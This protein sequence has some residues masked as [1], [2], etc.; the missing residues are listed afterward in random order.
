[1]CD[2]RRSSW[3]L[4]ENFKEVFRK[5]EEAPALG[6]DFRE[7]CVRSIVFPIDGISFVGCSIL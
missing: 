1:M 4:D 5:M 7:G 2:E 6:T 3:N